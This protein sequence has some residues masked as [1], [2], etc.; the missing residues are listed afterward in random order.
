MSQMHARPTP[1]RTEQTAGTTRLVAVSGEID[2]FTAPL[3]AIRLDDLTA[4][5]RPDLVVDLRPVSFVDCSGLGVLC[6]ARVRAR[7]RG[8]RMRLVST[9]ACFLRLL[10]ATGLGGAFEVLPRPPE[11]VEP[12]VVDLGSA[13]LQGTAAPVLVPWA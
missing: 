9:S 12:L 13:S 3:L 8:G 5:S 7:A 1:G 11:T 10:R 2:L 4:V 6:R